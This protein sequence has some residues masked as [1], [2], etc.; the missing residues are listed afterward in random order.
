MSRLYFKPVKNLCI[1]LN[2]M[3]EWV[4][5]YQKL[6]QQTGF[7]FCSHA[8]S[9]PVC[10]LY[11]WRRLPR[12]HLGSRVGLWGLTDQGIPLALHP[13]CT[14]SSF[15]CKGIA[16]GQTWFFS[17][18]GT[19]FLFDVPYFNGHDLPFIWLK[20]HFF[21]KSETRISCFFVIHG[22]ALALSH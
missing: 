4:L 1:S 6:D 13:S 2:N 21:F 10:C 9:C 11:I 15:G 14:F 20:V 16:S 17:F 19:S 22:F 7:W 5:C 12:Q 8:P 18:Y 3:L